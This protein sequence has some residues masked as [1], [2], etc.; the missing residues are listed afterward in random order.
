MGECWADQHDV[1]E[2]AVERAIE[3]VN[4]EPRFPRVRR[5]NHQDVKGDVARVHPDKYLVL[6]RLQLVP[7]N[8]HRRVTLHEDVENAVSRAAG[9]S[10][11]LDLDPILGVHE[12]RATAVHVLGRH[13]TEI[14]Q[15]PELVFGLKL[16]RIHVLRLVALFHKEAT[17]HFPKITWAEAFIV[18][19]VGRAIDRHA[20]FCQV[21]VEE[22]FG[23][24]GIRSVWLH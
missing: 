5:A 12:A 2:L 10:L 7:H 23:V 9:A 21:G 14:N 13:G 24:P 19:P 16:C 1:V 11:E 18:Q 22:F 3:L 20:D 8:V 4:H 15:K 17:N 6:D